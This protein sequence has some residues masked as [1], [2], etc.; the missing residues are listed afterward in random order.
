MRTFA[1]VIVFVAAICGTCFADSIDEAE[2]KSRGVSVQQVQLENAKAKIAD[3]QKQ[4][5]DLQGQ[6]KAAKADAEKL[7]QGAAASTAS[8]TTNP[9]VT[10][11]PDIGDKT[12]QVKGYVK[13]DG[14]YV[15]PY[16]RSAPKR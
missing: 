6:L 5:A 1:F 8:S 3:L 4:V 12:V 2:A 16:S 11:S 13:K 10:N 15:A 14:T 9:Y 7:R